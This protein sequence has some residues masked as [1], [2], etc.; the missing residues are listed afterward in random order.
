MKYNDLKR[1]AKE[2]KEFQKA[3]VNMGYNIENGTSY[4]DLLLQKRPYTQEELK[5]MYQ[6]QSDMNNQVKHSLVDE[7][8]KLNIPIKET[9]VIRLVN[10]NTGN[11]E[12]RKVETK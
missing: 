1:K 2:E 9:R 7:Y 4:L 5:Q 10:E 11:I 8:R 3:L 12:F 6:A